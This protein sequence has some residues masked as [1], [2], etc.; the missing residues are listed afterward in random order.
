M[1]AEDAFFKV[2]AEQGTGKILGAHAALLVQPLVYLMHAGNGDGG[3]L[4][5]RP[6]A[7]AQTIHP[8][9]SEVMIGA[10]GNLRRVEG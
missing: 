4:Y 1:G 2:I 6:L 8:A 5:R 3:E 9:L 7:R 10:F